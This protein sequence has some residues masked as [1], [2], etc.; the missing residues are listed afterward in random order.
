MSLKIR[1]RFDGRCSAHPR[2]NPEKDGQPQDKHCPGCDAL[3]VIHLYTG[4]ARR[5]AEL[6]EGIIFSRPG[7]L[8]DSADQHSLP[9]KSSPSTC[10]DEDSESSDQDTTSVA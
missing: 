3:W 5:K 6:G 1:F 8:S 9:D 4:I 2:Y 10:E 7:P